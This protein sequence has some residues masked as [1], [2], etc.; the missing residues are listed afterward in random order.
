M[1]TVVEY[2]G[3]ELGGGKAG[4]GVCRYVC[5]CSRDDAGNESGVE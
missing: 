1:N 5:S 4:P 2:Q 3:P